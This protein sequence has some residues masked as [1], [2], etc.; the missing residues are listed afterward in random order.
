MYT[1]SVCY[2]TYSALEDLV[3]ALKM[4]EVVSMTDMRPVN[5]I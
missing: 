2:T 3:F 5:G 1:T 4:L